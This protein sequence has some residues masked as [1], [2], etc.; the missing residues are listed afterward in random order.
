LPILL[1]VNVDED[2]AKTGFAA[3]DLADALPV[4][5]RLANL[6]LGG[7]MTV[8]RVVVEAEEARS[9]FRA[10]RILSERLRGPAPEVADP[11]EPAAAVA[12]G[13]GP[14][15]SMGMSG[16]YPVAIE[17][18]ATLVRV[19]R[20]I[21]GERASGAPEVAEAGPAPGDGEGGLV[22]GPTRPVVTERA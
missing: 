20:A 1:Q 5:L 21:F 11:G 12:R 16:D 4:L 10:L 14:A 18:G 3:D 8:G 15:L 13:L 7:L 19:G 22:P 9:T 2:P 6:E 17:E